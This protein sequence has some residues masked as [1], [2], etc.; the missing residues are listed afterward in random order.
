MSPSNCDVQTFSGLLFTRLGV[1]VPASEFRTLRSSCFV[2]HTLRALSTVVIVPEATL[3]NDYLRSYVLHFSMM[4]SRPHTGTHELPGIDSE[5]H[6]V[7]PQVS[8]DT[9]GIRQLRTDY[10]GRE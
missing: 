2:P 3:R 6:A 5:V 7:A 1:L 4:K 9:Q 8:P 10:R